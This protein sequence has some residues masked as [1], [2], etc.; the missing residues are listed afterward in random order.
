LT[1]FTELPITKNNNKLFGLKE[2]RAQTKLVRIDINQKKISIGEKYNIFV[3]GEPAYFAAAKLFRLMS[4]IDLDKQ[5]GGGTLLT[6]KK[7]WTWIVYKYDIIRGSAIYPFRV[8]KIWKRQ[9]Q[10]QA[11]SD[12]YDIYGQR[13]RKFSV[14]KNDRQVAWWEKEAVTWFQGDNY[15]ML[16]DKD[17]DLELL[18]A[19]CLIIDDSNSNRNNGDTLTIDYGYF[20]SGVKAFDPNWMPKN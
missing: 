3:E 1:I 4:E 6:I 9:Y 13:G 2:R 14:Y 5:S 8:K 10:C 16:L 11:D 12:L 20:G 19:F 7:R 17:S 15:K 18:I